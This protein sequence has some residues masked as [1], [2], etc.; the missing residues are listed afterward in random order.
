MKSQQQNIKEIEQELI[1]KIGDLNIED[2]D[3]SQGS[4]VDVSFEN[5]D[6]EILISI[7]PSC[8]YTKKQKR[9]MESLK[10]VNIFNP[11]QQA[12]T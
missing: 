8:S 4:D 7:I 10:E 6:D 1:S 12:K 11:L 9:L 5:L 2:K 3:D